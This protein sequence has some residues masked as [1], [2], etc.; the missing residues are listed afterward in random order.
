MWTFQLPTKIVFGIGTTASMATMPEIQDRRLVIVTDSTIGQLPPI[1]NLIDSLK[2]NAVYDKV[3]PNPTTAN[4][5]EVTEL[6]RKIDAEIIVAIGG[7][8]SLDTAK[9]ASCLAWTND[10]SIRSYHSEG[11]IFQRVGIP[12]ITVPTT[13]G[14]GSEVTPIAVLDD[15][16]KNFKSPMASPYFYPVCAVVDPELTISVPLRVTASTALDAL[17][18]SIEGYWSKNHQPICDL[19]AKEAAKTIFVHLPNVYEN[20]DDLASR[21]ALSYAALIAGIAFHLPK[22]AIIHA[23]SFPLSNRAHLPH[24]IAC[25]F[26]MEAAIRM[27]SPYMNGRMEEFAAYCNFSTI[28]KM[29][30]EITT[31][32]RRGGLP[33]TLMEAQIDSSLIDTLIAESFHPLL[34]NNPKKVTE[35]DLRQIYKELMVNE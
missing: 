28:E 27:N 5:D 18:H 21:K 12:V 20:L 34:N 13:A 10:L 23:C 8:S 4:V 26:T 25:A 32:K 30:E 35:E 31:L 7:G 1:R 14:T 29:I 3:R 17:S 15:E 19:L 9:A 2:P 11:K 6:L 16:G 24:G 33:C 22:N